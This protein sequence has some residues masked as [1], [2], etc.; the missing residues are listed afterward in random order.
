MQ[1]E[2]CSHPGSCSGLELSQLGGLFAPARHLLNP[3]PGADRLAIALM[4]RWASVDGGVTACLDVLRNMGRD[5]GKAGVCHEIPGVVVLVA[6]QRI[7]MRNR[8]RTRY[9]QSRSPLAI[10]VRQGHLTGQHQTM[11]VFHE[12]VAQITEVGPGAVRL[13]EQLRLDITAGAVGLIGDKQTSEIACDSLLPLGGMPGAGWPH[14]PA[15]A[16]SAVGMNCE[17][18]INPF[19]SD[20]THKSELV[21]CLEVEL[22]IGIDGAQQPTLGDLIRAWSR[23]PSQF[24]PTWLVD[25]AIPTPSL[26]EWLHPLWHPRL[27][28]WQCLPSRSWSGLIPTA[29]FMLR[30]PSIVK[31]LF[32]EKCT[33]RPARLATKLCWNGHLNWYPTSGPASCMESREPA[34]MV[35]VSLAIC[36][37]PVIR[38]GRSTVPIAKLAIS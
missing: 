3:L 13:A 21:S 8:E 15:A 27:R 6:C 29:T 30:W 34:L 28:Q 4:A 35:L 36:K 11:A 26:L 19:S 22:S 10:S 5:A 20:L 25:G 7:L 2:H 33:C 24:C 32:W 9:P 37:V 12:A 17:H 14:P 38:C 1:P 16:R 18:Q 23:V 31:A